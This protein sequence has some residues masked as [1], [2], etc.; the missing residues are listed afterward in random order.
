MLNSL[1]TWLNN[2][3]LIDLE[4]GVASTVS[5]RQTGTGWVHHKIHQMI[6]TLRDKSLAEITL[7][8][9]VYLS[10]AI[11]LS[12]F[13]VDYFLYLKNPSTYTPSVMWSILTVALIA[14]LSLGAFT[15]MCDV[16]EDCLDNLSLFL[17][18]GN[19][20]EGIK[21]AVE[22]FWSEVLLTTGIFNYIFSPGSLNCPPWTTFLLSLSS[23]IL[24]GAYLLSR[25]LTTKRPVSQTRHAL[26][27]WVAQATNAQ[28]RA[29][30]LVA[31][32]RIMEAIKSHR[33]TLSGL[34]LTELPLYYGH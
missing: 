4:D 10:C 31:K 19:I 15:M 17:G 29:N 33:L 5:L 24:L 16:L 22:S 3:P 6:T 9:M 18:R 7:K 26:L 11:S 14:P 8:P 23:N 20:Y 12:L 25:F 1:H 13:T 2:P 28:E 34:R 27:S 21:R 30:R 32:E